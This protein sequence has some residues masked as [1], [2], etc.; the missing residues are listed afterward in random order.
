MIFLKVVNPEAHAESVKFEIQGI[1]SL[2]GK[3]DAITLAG[4]PEDS[5]SLKQPRNLV[6]VSTTLDPVSPAFSH[7]LPAHSIVVLKL[8]AR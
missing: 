1:P 2:A 7:T 8:K 5:N 6:P 4:N 3:A